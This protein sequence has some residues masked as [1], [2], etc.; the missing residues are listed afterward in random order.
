[1]RAGRGN[2]AR[3]LGLILKGTHMLTRWHATLLRSTVRPV[4]WAAGWAEHRGERCGASG[5]CD[6]YAV[7]TCVMVRQHTMFHLL[8]LLIELLLAGAARQRPHRLQKLVV[9]H[10]AHVRDAVTEGA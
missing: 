9:A 10:V 6:A 5:A 1:M 4:S 8:H 3:M 2:A 7:S